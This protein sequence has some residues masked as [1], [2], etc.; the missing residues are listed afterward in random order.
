MGGPSAVH[1][2]RRRLVFAV[3]AVAVGL[4]T[5]ACSTS[6]S[7]SSSSSPA[8]SATSA[9]ASQGS[10][11]ATAS[12]A[13][14]INIGLAALVIPGV[15]DAQTQYLAGI[16]AAEG[17]VNAHGGWDGRSVN[18]QECTTSGT[19][20]A[21]ASCY[22]QFISAHVMAV[23]GLTST[24]SVWLPQLAKAGIPDFVLQQ[25]QAEEKSPWEMTWTPSPIELFTVAAKY[26]CVHGLKSVSLLTTQLPSAQVA[27]AAYSNSI[28]SACGIHVN[29]VYAPLGAPD[30][31]PYVEKAVSSKPQLLVMVGL[32]ATAAAVA[33]A[34]HTS[35]YPMSQVLGVPNG[36]TG[37][38]TNPDSY[39]WLLLT[40]A[41]YPIPQ[42]T[43][44]DIQ[45]FLQ[46]MAKYSPGSDPTQNLSMTGFQNIYT[47]WEIGKAIGFSKL[48]GQA[49]YQYMN[50]V[51]PGHLAIFAE[52][53]EVIPAGLPGVKNPYVQVERW[54]G[55]QLVH[56]GWLSG[57]WGC[58]SAASCASLTPPAGSLG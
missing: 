22:R 51:A 15:Y 24:N 5:A 18:V 20:A 29:A 38:Q 53:T 55:S 40:E 47:I 44:P 49:I 30:L 50:T 32:Q 13:G 34:I 31:S 9:P 35:G 28:Y 36:S 4:M 48:T 25:T 11:S 6:S 26:A 43:N 54:T 52:R 37:W 19:P 14:P 27:E 7:T 1:R 21:D 10:A 57:D 39:G 45:T 2:R 56:L 23:I 33:S 8:A 3:I 16:K 58:T 42:E 41:G 46:A 17:Y 12:S